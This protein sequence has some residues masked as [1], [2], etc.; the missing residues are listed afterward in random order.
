MNIH[1]VFCDQSA[2][3]PLQ[4]LQYLNSWRCDWFLAH[5]DMLTDACQSSRALLHAAGRQ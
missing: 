1:L 2:A 4:C 3:V 5:D